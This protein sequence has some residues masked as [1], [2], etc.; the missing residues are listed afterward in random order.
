MS[1][2]LKDIP[3]PFHTIGTSELDRINDELKA[4]IE[5]VAA[6]KSDDNPLLLIYTPATTGWE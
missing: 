6:S 2:Y 3:I 5:E 4:I 1:D